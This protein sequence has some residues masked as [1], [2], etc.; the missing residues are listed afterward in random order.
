MH[1]EKN[2]KIIVSLL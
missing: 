2:V 1:G